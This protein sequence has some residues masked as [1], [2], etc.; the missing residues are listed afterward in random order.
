[1]IARL[2]R[3][4]ISIWSLIWS[5]FSTTRSLTFLV[6]MTAVA[7]VVVV[8]AG[9]AAIGLT[10]MVMEDAP[11][12]LYQNL[13]ISPPR[14]IMDAKK[15]GYLMLLG[16]DAP[17]GLDPLQAGYERKPGL[18]DKAAA[19]ICSGGDEAKEGTGSAGASGQVVTN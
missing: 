17:A 14:T 18:Q 2:H 7:V 19:Q 12:S 5:C 16:F 8:A 3:I 1:L 6:L 11:S 10:W 13:T 4:R 9:L 15:N